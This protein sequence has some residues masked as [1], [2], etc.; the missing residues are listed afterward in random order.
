VNRPLK[1]CLECGELSDGSRCPKH[2]RARERARGSAAARGYGSQYRALRKL[3]IDAHLQKY[4]AVCPGYGV[5]PH[6]ATRAELSVDHII[7]LADGGR[8]DPTNVQVICLTCNKRK[9]RAH[10]VAVDRLVPSTHTSR[11]V[12]GPLIA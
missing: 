4:G 11:Q 9:G 10:D 8:N 12:R 6:T 2:R 1:T 7:P 3:A 5:A